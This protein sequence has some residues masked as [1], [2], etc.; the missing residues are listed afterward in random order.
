MWSVPERMA[1][2]G[3]WQRAR[4]MRDTPHRIGSGSPG[5]ACLEALCPWHC[6]PVFRFAQS[7][8]TTTA[9]SVTPRGLL[10]APTASRANSPPEQAIAFDELPDFC[11]RR[12]GGSAASHP[13]RLPSRRAGTD[14]QKRVHRRRRDASGTAPALCSPASPSLP[15]RK[16]V[17]QTDV[18]TRITGNH[19]ADGRSGATSNVG[20]D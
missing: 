12:G 20:S 19:T 10:A 5:R 17:T 11:I 13:M 1:T 15:A 14:R 16:F 3:R 6:R 7:G 18:S 2:R 8:L 4:R 9:V